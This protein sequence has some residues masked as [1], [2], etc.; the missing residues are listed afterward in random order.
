M[1]ATSPADPD[2]PCAVLLHVDPSCPFAW[3]TSRWLLEV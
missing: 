3:L 2:R 1:E